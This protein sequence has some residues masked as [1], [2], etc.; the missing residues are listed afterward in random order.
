M[1]DFW[2]HQTNGLIKCLEKKK[3]LVTQ[4][5]LSLWDPMCCSH[6]GN[7]GFSHDRQILYLLKMSYRS[8]FLWC[9]STCSF[10]CHICKILG[11]L[12]VGQWKQA[13]RVSLHIFIELLFHLAPEDL[14]FLQPLVHMV[15]SC[16]PVFL[17]TDS[18]SVRQ[19]A[20]L[21]SH[22]N[23]Y[24]FHKMFYKSFFFIEICAFYYAQILHK[25]S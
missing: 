10:I 5:C 11:F 1:T 13:V 17:C 7:L 4:S 23:P 3:V 25:M 16:N 8:V 15:F 2:R 14:F 21:S 24:L 6:Q 12:F 18:R 9:W 20:E 22:S 19:R